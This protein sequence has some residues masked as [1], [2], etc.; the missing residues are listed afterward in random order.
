MGLLLALQYAFAELGARRVLARVL[1]HNAASL[2]LHR[3]LGFA[4][5]QPENDGSRC[6]ALEAADFAD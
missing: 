3:K 2:A 6:F 5:G 1:P 4:E